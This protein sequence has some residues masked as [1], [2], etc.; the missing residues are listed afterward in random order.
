MD[1]NFR[2]CWKW[3]T[4]DCVSNSSVSAKVGSCWG[5]LD[6]QFVLSISSR[7]WDWLEG[8]VSSLPDEPVIAA[9]QGCR[10]TPALHWCWAVVR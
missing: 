4:F 8:A 6:R 5:W 10:N 9:L 2:S 3:S 1:G 7:P